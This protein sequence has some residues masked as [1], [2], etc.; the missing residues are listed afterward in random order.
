MEEA[1]AYLP[2]RNHAAALATTAEPHDYL[3]QARAIYN[4]AIEHWRYVRDPYH[5]ETLVTTGP[6][7]MQFV[8]GFGDGVGR[9]LGAGDCDD[10]ALALGSEFLA[11]GLP[12]RLVTSSEA[13][14]PDNWT[15]VFLQVDI[16][17]HGW[18]SVDPVLHPNQGFGETV[19]AARLGYWD[20]SGNLYDT[21]NL[22]GFH[23]VSGCK[24]LSG[25]AL[26]GYI[27]TAYDEPIFELEEMHCLPGE[28]GTAIQNMGYI[29][30]ANELGIELGPRDYLPDGSGRAIAP[31]LAMEP[32]AYEYLTVV[33][34]PHL[35]MRAVGNT[36][37]VYEW[38]EQVP[39]LGGPIGRFFKRIGDGIKWFFRK[40]WKGIKK[41][42]QATKFGRW[43]LRVAGGILKFA[44]KI[45]GPFAKWI[46]KYAPIIAGVVAII[47]GVGPV[48][49]GYI[50]SV[51]AVANAYNKYA[52]PVVKAIQ[53]VDGQEVEFDIPQFANL[54]QAVNVKVDMLTDSLKMP[55]ISSAEVASIRAQI[56]DIKNMSQDD[57]NE[58]NEQMSEIGMDLETGTSDLTPEQIAQME[59]LEN[60]QN[61][62]LDKIEMTDGDRDRINA[63]MANVNLDDPYGRIVE[64]QLDQVRRASEQSNEA[65]AQYTASAAQAAQARAFY[66][67]ANSPEVRIEAANRQTSAAAHYEVQREGLLM[68]ERAA[69]AERAARTAKGQ[70]DSAVNQIQE[71]GYNVSIFEV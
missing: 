22:M 40:I 50:M 53:I 44:G 17:G 15:H 2:L 69:M 65:W 26:S 68:Q 34:F 25:C 35:G 67:R 36:G 61:L 71:I 38:V 28:I 9:G 19:P 32:D 6:Q 70:F 57:L 20:L 39:P 8:L 29:G 47:P 37:Y 52:V 24:A 45:M 4:D 66:E 59:N 56:T 12:I 1:Q 51:G 14:H 48:I 33:G 54:E 30:D 13:E 62:V 18:V 60:A 21:E 63:Y 42:F 41:V 43:I 27:E 16:P 23:S 64:S 55:D 10:I 3:G 5:Y 49:A 46:G 7:I 31:F 58:L 11:I